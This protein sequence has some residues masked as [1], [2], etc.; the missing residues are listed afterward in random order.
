MDLAKTRMDGSG[1]FGA[2]AADI[3]ATCGNTP[4]HWNRKRS[5]EML[6]VGEGLSD[7]GRLDAMPH[8]FYFLCGTC[9]L[10]W[11]GMVVIEVLPKL[12]RTP[13][14]MCREGSLCF[15]WPFLVDKGWRCQMS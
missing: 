12:I 9:Q 6:Q 3:V 1:Q 7:L 15:V 4:K 10:Q 11:Y 2:R 14:W 5:F 13:F 8:L